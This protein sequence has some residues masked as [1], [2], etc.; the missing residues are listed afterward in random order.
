MILEACGQKYIKV[1]LKLNFVPCPK[2]EKSAP[3]VRNIITQ[4][5][6]VQLN[7]VKFQYLKQ[8]LKIGSDTL[9]V[10]RILGRRTSHFD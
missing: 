10:L 4:S 3:Y 9:S 2:H 6:V 5:K 8:V 1:K 7:K